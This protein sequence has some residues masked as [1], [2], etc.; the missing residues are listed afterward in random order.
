MIDRPPHDKEMS[1]WEHL[2]ELGQRLK[3]VL[4]ASLIVFL[5]MW[6]PAPLTG[7]GNPLTTVLF[8]VDLYRPFG[9]WL[10]YQS[11]EPI[12]TELN[13]TTRIQIVLIWG[14]VWNPLAS[15]VYSSAY[16]T[17]LI[18]FP[19]F[20]YEMWKYI[21]PA[22]YPHEERAVKKYLGGS[23]ILFYLGNLFSIYVIFPAVFRFTAN[24]ATILGLSQ[25]VDISSVVNTW[26]T[27]ALMSGVIFETPVVMAILSEICVLNPYSVKEYRPVVYA[28]ALILIAVI[29]PDPTVVSTILLFIPF[30]LLFELGLVFSKRIF[31]RCPEFQRPR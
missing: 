14:Q 16:I 8:N 9:Y 12:V 18:V 20:V 7:A 29:T 25:I 30:I 31:K 3:R 4:I 17:A 15:V 13:K 23:L 21:K 1:I 6:L 2:A 26:I 28:A 10:F 24:F 27:L 5:I 11:I 22:L 19:Y